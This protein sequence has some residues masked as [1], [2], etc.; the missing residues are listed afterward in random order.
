MRPFSSKQIMVNQKLKG[1]TCGALAAA[2]YGMNPLFALPLY[3]QGMGVDS[4]LFY[5]YF[6]AIILIGILMKVQGQSFALKKSEIVPLAVMGLLF[7]ASSFLLFISYD[8][9][10]AGIAS[11]ILFIYPVL[12]AIIM[13]VFFHEKVSLLTMF[14]IALAF[15]GISLLC[16]GEGGKTLNMLGVL[17][18]FLSSLTYAIYMVGINRSSLRELP[19]AKLTFYSLLFGILIYVVRLK[20]CTELQMVPSPELW[21]NVVSLAL[22]PT[23]I[24]LLAMTVAIHNIGSTFTAILGALEPV[25]A[26]FFGVMVFGEQLTP[27]IV[28]GIVLVLLA[29]TLIIAAKPLAALAHKRVKH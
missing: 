19:T 22:F 1:F 2:T 10:D 29:V 5:R 13:A 9:M 25:T 4:V 7:S 23:I 18:V 27:R 3:A 16:K 8:Y 11:T 6:F 12:V 14:S 28:L 26:L 20:G 21:V 15:V 17:F 24:S